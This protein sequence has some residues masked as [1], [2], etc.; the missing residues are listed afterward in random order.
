MRTIGA[1]FFSRLSKSPGHRRSRGLQSEL[2]RLR[3]R[4]KDWVRFAKTAPPALTASALAASEPLAEACDWRPLPNQNSQPLRAGGEPEL[5]LVFLSIP[6]FQKREVMS[7]PT[8]AEI[9]ISGTASSVSAQGRP[10]F[11]R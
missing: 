4:Q 10:R 2:A 8:H 6:H 9:H 3:S 1:P 11:P 7:A 5:D